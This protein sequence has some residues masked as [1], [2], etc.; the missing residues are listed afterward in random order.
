MNSISGG[1]CAPV[2][3]VSSALSCGIKT[4]GSDKLDLVLIYSKYPTVGSAVFTTNRVKAAPVQLSAESIGRKSPRAILA[5][6]G[7]ANACTGE[8][9]LSDATRLV[10][11]TAE[12]LE[13]ETDEISNCSTGIIGLPMPMD[14]IL[15]R[16]PDL[17]ESLGGDGDR[18]AEA[19]MTSDTRPKSVA[20]EYR[21]S[22]GKL[23]RIGA[24]AKGA[25]MINP[26]MATMLCFITTDA[27]ISKDT[28]D[29]ALRNAVHQSFNCISVD[30]DMS[31]NDTVI[32][33]A[34]GQAGNE[35]DS[36]LDLFQ[37]AL[38]DVTLTLAKKM[39]SDGERV[40]KLVKV[41]VSGAVCGEDA[42]KVARAVANS[43][44]VKCSWNGNDPNWGRVIHAVG[45]A[46]AEICEDQIDISFSG[47][48]ACIGGLTANTP[49]TEL[50]EAVARDEFSVEINLNLGEGKFTM[51]TA[52]LSP[53]YVTFNREEYALTRRKLD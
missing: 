53:E 40:T 28:L 24:I 22:D 6:S 32:I 3:F 15:P 14:R 33:M 23:I 43:N 42:E 12:L 37:E 25:G 11:R 50:A 34:N 38:N 4:A 35:A 27:V 49:L 18:A 31:T 41:Q 44:L 51:Y 26:N 13:L 7:N 52:D 46:G 5:N 20:V 1:I 30:G 45:Y 2:G 10:K 36:D 9:G 39:V 29:G 17:V 8:R 21:D 16:I 48:P 47:K 19:I